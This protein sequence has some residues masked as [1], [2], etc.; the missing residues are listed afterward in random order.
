MLVFNLGLTACALDEGGLGNR[1][2]A[3][4][5]QQRKLGKDLPKTGRDPPADQSVL[6]YVTQNQGPA[7]DSTH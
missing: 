4:L 5:N 2:I 3:E 6:V 1:S 7:G